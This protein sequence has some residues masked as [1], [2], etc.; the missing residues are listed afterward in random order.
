MEKD[1]NGW[2]CSVSLCCSFLLNFFHHTL[3]GTLAWIRNSSRGESFEQFFH[4]YK[5]SHSETSSSNFFFSSNFNIKKMLSRVETSITQQHRR[6]EQVHSSAASEK[7]NS[8]W[9][10][11]RCKNERRRKIEKIRRFTCKWK[12]VLREINKLKLFSFCLPS[13]FRQH[14]TPALLFMFSDLLETRRASPRYHST[15]KARRRVSAT[16]RQQQLNFGKFFLHLITANILLLPRQGRRRSSEW[17]LSRGN[18]SQLTT[19]CRREMRKTL[20]FNRQ[21]NSAVVENYIPH[22]FPLLIG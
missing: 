3:L 19:L 1:G 12:L 5:I 10:Q 8:T 4:E 2:M 21:F 22:N 14:N 11:F 15:Q 17:K 18:G 9:D 7:W 20:T 13:H 6:L 16:L